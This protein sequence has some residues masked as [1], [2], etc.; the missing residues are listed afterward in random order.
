MGMQP[1]WYLKD[2]KGKVVCTFLPKVLKNIE[3]KYGEKTDCFVRLELCFKNGE[4]K[5]IVLSL[6]GIDNTDWPKIDRRCIIHSNYRNAGKFIANVIRA[7]S[8]SAAVETKYGIERMGIHHIGNTILFAAGD[9]VITR[10]SDPKSMPHIELSKLPFSLDI[11]PELTAREAFNGMRELIAINPELGNVLVA[12]AVSGIMGAAF[13]ENRFDSCTV[14]VIVGKSGML[15]SSYVPHMIQLYNRKGEIRAV[16]RFN[17]TQRYIEEILCDYS[18]CTVVVDD[19]HTAESKAIK[20]RNEN[21]F[22]EIIRR[23][24]DNTMRGRMEGNARKEN[25]FRGNVV[26]IGEYTIGKASTIPRELVVNITKKPDER[27]LDKFQRQKP[28]LVST[29]YYYFIQ[30]YVD[31]FDAICDEIGKRLTAFREKNAGSE[32]HGR[33]RDAQF[34]L[35]ISYMILLEYCIESGFI[36]QDEANE[37]YSSFG[38]QIIKLVQ[39]QQARFKAGRENSGD[40]DYLK[41]IRRFYKSKR[42]R[43]ADSEKTFD[44]DKHDGLIYNKY[45]CLC[46]RSASLEKMLWKVLPDVSMKNVITFLMAKKALK[47]DRDKNT[48]KISTLN[49][50]VG[51]KRFYAIWLSMLE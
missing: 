44:P 19:L 1:E 33:L 7:E 37:A 4:N 25:E 3:I 42:F 38:D 45:K 35:Q 6:T 23:I 17:S 12:H 15:K 30:W 41:L 27:V 31:N 39:A 47:H 18:E 10:S 20:R 24:G 21:T 5:V 51:S 26:F 34:Y 40:V 22:E 8:I 50:N 11:D 14:L 49:K 43:L 28:L 16:T 46:L 9:R 32:I 36:S 29:F 13:L 48:V 2:E